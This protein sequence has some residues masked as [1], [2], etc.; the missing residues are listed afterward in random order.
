MSEETTTSTLSGKLSVLKSRLLKYL[1]VMVILLA[2]LFAGYVWLTLHW[3]YADGERAGYLQKFSKK[4]WLCKTWEGELSLVALPGVAP[5]KFLFTVRDDEVAK[6]VSDAVG[7]HVDLLYA[8]H[9][10]V[11][12]TCFGDTEYFVNGV[13]II[14]Q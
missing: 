13:K 12:S 8:Q 1:V 6:R 9:R 5:E 3:S 4:G 2:V 7:K 14:G 10:G 11:V